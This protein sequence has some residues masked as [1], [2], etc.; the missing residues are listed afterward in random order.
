M[1]GDLPG[2]NSKKCV[3]RWGEQAREAAQVVRRE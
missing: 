2:N 1:G 3:W